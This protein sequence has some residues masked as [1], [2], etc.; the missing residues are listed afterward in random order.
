MRA[1]VY[2]ILGLGLVGVVGCQSTHK[3]SA[4]S[5]SSKHYSNSKTKS[6]MDSV[7]AVDADLL[8]CSL[9]SDKRIIKRVKP[10]AGGCQVSYTKMGETKVVADAKNDLVYCDKIMGK[11]KQNLTQAGFGC[12]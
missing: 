12:K 10:E 7:K 3:K 1:A 11:I 9:G 8:T 5:K 4:K 2:I 6:G